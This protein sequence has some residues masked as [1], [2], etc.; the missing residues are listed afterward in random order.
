[1]SNAQLTM[2]SLRK[3]NTKLLVEIAELRKKFAKIESENAEIPKLR[4]KVAENEVE[5]MKLRQELKA[6]TDELEKTISHY[7][8]KIELIPEVIAKQLV[9]AVNIPVMDQCETSLKDK[10]IDAFLGE[11]HKKKVFQFFHHL[12]FKD[13][14]FTLLQ[15]GCWTLW[16]L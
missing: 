4:K 12:D 5:K 13:N 10:K 11:M 14:F 16:M 15:I 7:S 9:S 2:D 6:R 3:L 8:I 1:M